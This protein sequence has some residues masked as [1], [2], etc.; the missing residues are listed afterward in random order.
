MLYQSVSVCPHTVYTIKAYAKLTASPPP[1]RHKIAKPCYLQVCE[2]GRCSHDAHMSTKLEAIEWKF[3]TSEEQESA[4]IR[5]L[6]TCPDGR[7]G[8]ISTVYL[9]QISVY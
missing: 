2:N 3:E 6:I 7:R 4:E 9:D 8:K 1:F 5:V